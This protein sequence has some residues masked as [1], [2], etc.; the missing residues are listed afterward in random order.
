MTKPEALRRGFRRPHEADPGETDLP[1][2]LVVSHVLPISSRS[3]QE[4]RVR[5]S[6][7][8]FRRSYHV[9]FCS[10]VR[11][12]QQESVRQGLLGLCDEALLFTSKSQHGVVART[13]HR[14]AG[15]AYSASTGL[16]RSNYLIGQVDFSP[17]HI[18]K[19]IDDRKFDCVLFEYWHSWRASQ[20]LRLRGLPTVLDTHNIL[21]KSRYQQLDQRSWIPLGI[22]RWSIRRYRRAEEKAWQAYDAIIAINRQEHQV[23]RACVP[24]PT[25]VF[26]APMGIDLSRWPFSWSPPKD[27]RIAYYGGLGSPHNQQ[28]A[29][30]CLEAIM[31]A[32]WRERPQA[33]LY[34]IGSNPP[35]SILAMQSDPR[36]IVTGFVDNIPPLLAKM[37]LVLCPWRGTFGF[38]SRLVEIAAVGVPIIAS[39]DAVDGMDFDSGHDILLSR[40]EIEMAAQAVRLLDHPD[41]AVSQSRAARRRVEDSW[42][43]QATYDR[44]VDETS[45]WL[46]SRR[47]AV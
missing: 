9:T 46:E 31:P 19:L 24:E 41:E 44:L 17:R 18:L 25:P 11:P 35:P 42:S 6:L 37:S 27:T 5:Y 29:R 43:V 39:Y 16:K 13:W 14:L 30:M 34:L 23:I 32:I 33:Q 40:D 47:T 1:R 36:V 3:G 21:W 7:E 20:A 45:A 28:S 38:R 4:Q 2:L 8:A 26:Y 15:V 12:E 10:A 22:R